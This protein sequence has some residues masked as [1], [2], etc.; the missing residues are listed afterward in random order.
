[1]RMEGMT[2]ENGWEILERVIDS[3]DGSTWLLL[4]MHA[5][6]TPPANLRIAVSV[7]PDGKIR[8]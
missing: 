8:D 5:S 7:G 2:R 6:E 1:M 4:P 3:D